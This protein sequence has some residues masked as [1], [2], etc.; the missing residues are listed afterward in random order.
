MAYTLVAVCIL[1]LR[2]RA[3]D[4]SY[5]DK[6]PPTG[7]QIMRQ[8]FNLNFIKVPNTLTSNVTKSMVFFFALFTSAFCLLFGD[9][10][11]WNESSG[12]LAALIILGVLMCVSLVAIIRQPR[13]RTKSSFQ[14][15]AVPF[16][17][18]LSIF[19]NLYLMFQLDIHTWIRFGVWLAIGYVIYFT[20]GIRKSVEGNRDKLELS[21]N[22]QKS[23]HTYEGSNHPRQVNVHSMPSMDNLQ[24]ANIEF[25]TGSTVQLSHK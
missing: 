4:D 12:M 23:K 20:Y 11:K 2:Y 5:L 6:I 15:P 13:N 18:L 7:Q 24:N 3:D 19:M 17:P 14:V 8:L 9:G 16:L 25:T 1:E 21:E 22:G 10:S